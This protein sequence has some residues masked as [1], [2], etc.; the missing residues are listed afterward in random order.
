MTSR[1]LVRGRA[2]PFVNSAILVG[3]SAT[4]TYYGWKSYRA[5]GDDAE[6]TKV[7]VEVKFGEADRWK[8]VSPAKEP[9]LV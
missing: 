6:A 5:G 4:C 3:L 7:V 2:L 8:R 1:H 9:I